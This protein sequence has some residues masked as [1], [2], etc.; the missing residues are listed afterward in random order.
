MIK[1]VADTNV[2]LSAILFGG[3]P[4]KV[5]YLAR[6]G[7]IQLFIS[8]PILA[9]LSEVLRKKF[10]WSSWQIS[11]VDLFIREQ[12]TVVIPDR[13]LNII[14]DYEADNRI[15]EC[16]LEADADFIISGDKRHLLFLREFAGKKIVSPGDFLTLFETAD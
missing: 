11:Q 7:Q 10:G 3:K 5:M 14:K 16:A 12:T 2:Y 15:L 8:L 4:E 13:K 1:A 9:E 6:N